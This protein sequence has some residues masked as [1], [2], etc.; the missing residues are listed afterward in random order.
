MS[1][2][3]AA[4][5]ASRSAGGG[6][7]GGSPGNSEPKTKK[8]RLATSEHK[9]ETDEELY[10]NAVALVFGGELYAK[11]LSY[12]GEEAIAHFRD[13]YRWRTAMDELSE[14]DKKA[15]E[16]PSVPRPSDMDLTLLRA[17]LTEPISSPHTG[18][19]GTW[20]LN[21]LGRMAPFPQIRLLRG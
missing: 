18:G 2:S 7:G 15:L 1:S 12:G 14:A 21:K 3:G 16:L 4:T 10:Q 19:S 9:H 13:D 17:L 6:N 11:L 8:Q 5:G 20:A